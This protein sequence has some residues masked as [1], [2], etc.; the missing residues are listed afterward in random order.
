[1]DFL[2]L[3]QSAA[4]I[5]AA[6]LTSVAALV[7]VSRGRAPD[8]DL[9]AQACVGPAE[10]PEIVFLFD[11]ESLVDASAAAQRLLAATPPNGS[12]IA[13]LVAFLAPR[14][15]DLHDTV[16][17]SGEFDVLDLVSSDGQ[18]R[19]CVG[20]GGSRLKIRLED[21]SD[22]AQPGVD[23][24][25]FLAL[26][27][28]VSMHRHLEAALPVPVWRQSA[29][30]RITW[31]NAAYQDL[32]QTAGAE[33]S[34]GGAIAD[35]FDLEGPAAI[36]SDI[37]LRVQVRT[38]DQDQPR[39]FDCHAS[40]LGGDYLF[41][42]T[43]ATRVVQAERKLRDFVETLTQTFAHL[44][45][46]LAIFD[47]ARRLTVFNPALTELL[48]LPAEYLISHPSL[49]QFLD[50]LRER[51]TMPEPKDYKTWRQQMSVLEAAA[52]D[53]SYSETWALA[54]GRTFRVTG[55]PHTDGAVAFLFEDIS[56]E[57]TLTRQ[58]RAELETG[59]AVI[60]SLDEAIAVFSPAGYLTMSNRVYADMW[61]CDPCT[62][63]G[64]VSFLD[65]TRRWQQACAPT[66][67]WGDAR[68]FAATLGERSN[69]T[70][71]VRLLDGR[72]L[73]CRF[74]ALPGGATLAA[75][76]ESEMAVFAPAEPRLE[77]ARA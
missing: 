7:L 57:I 61:D 68:D 47:R 25:T 52:K 27:D 41:T 4:M 49:V 46:G 62:S 63:L 76:A 60:D 29:E 33:A 36:A 19:L 75:F 65:A 66:P 42:A 48:G 30:G 15:P 23:R 56:S 13:R 17:A 9:S 40:R 21:A 39:W 10:A 71:E 51:R 37:G 3:A 59:Q 74:E 54:D 67:V 1:M 2:S 35:L 6:L 12:D 73:S 45:V 34:P 22:I 72:R 53:G 70:A 44:N 58:F 24:H 26:T 69:W 50:Q 14:F 55:R 31:A 32:A 77:P 28:E 8:A 18:T 20:I 43:P 64:E 38:K 11:G 16:M 5:F